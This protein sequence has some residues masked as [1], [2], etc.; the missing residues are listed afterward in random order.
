MAIA[1]KRL[2]KIQRL[3][4]FGIMGAMYTIC[5]G[6]VEALASLHWNW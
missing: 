6:A 1:K 3:A 4:S 5:T 2:Y